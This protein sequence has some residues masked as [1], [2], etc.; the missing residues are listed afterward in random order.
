M[1]PL[2]LAL[3]LLLAAPV[4]KDFKKA[5]APALDGAWRLTADQTDDIILAAEK[6]TWQCEGAGLTIRVPGQAARARG[7]IHFD[8]A[9]TPHTFDLGAR[10]G[11]CQLKGDTLTVCLG[12]SNGAR[13]SNLEGGLG[14]RKLTFARV[15]PNK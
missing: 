10:L 13:P 14:V 12:P 7:P 9:T 4:P 8:P 3:P 1:T 5:E 6:M 2:L 15:E 11:V